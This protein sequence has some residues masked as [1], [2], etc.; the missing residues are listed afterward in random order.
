MQEKLKCS[1]LPQCASRAG[2]DLAALQSSVCRAKDDCHNF[3]PECEQRAKEVKD[4]ACRCY[5]EIKVEM[6][7]D[8]VDIGDEV[9]CRQSTRTAVLCR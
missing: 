3:S 5:D 2:I 4:S 7:K 8:G 6:E 9:R 1:S